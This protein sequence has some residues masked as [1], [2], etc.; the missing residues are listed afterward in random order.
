VS[1]GMKQPPP[2]EVYDFVITLVAM[3]IVPITAVILVA[4]ALVVK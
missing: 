4:L 2:A 3:T 1:G